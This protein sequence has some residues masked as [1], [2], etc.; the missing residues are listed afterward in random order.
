ML[1]VDL[2]RDGTRLATGGEDFS[3]R[4]WDASTGRMIT[5]IEG[6]H[7]DRP[8]HQDED[9]SAGRMI[10]PLTGYGGPVVC[11]ALSPACDR[12]AA[13]GWAKLRIDEPSGGRFAGSSGF[14]WQGGYLRVWDSGTGKL[15]HSLAETGAGRP[16]VRAMAFTPDGNELFALHEDYTLNAWDAR[17]GRKLVALDGPRGSI[18]S[19][20]G[21]SEPGL[22][23]A[24]STDG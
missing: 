1:A 23:A 20:R 24:F 5:A 17:T 2:S 13:C 22:G 12:V 4:F 11:V 6:V 3:L 7:R 19:G 18:K 15:I 16:F 10:G 21:R 14:A 8:R 9:A